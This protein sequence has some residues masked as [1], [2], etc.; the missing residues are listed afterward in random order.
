MS[1]IKEKSDS[2]SFKDNDNF[3]EFLE[4]K[5]QIINLLQVNCEETNVKSNKNEKISTRLKNEILN[6]IPEK[7]FY[8]DFVARNNLSSSKVE[9]NKTQKIKKEFSSSSISRIIFTENKD[10]L[11]ISNE[12]NERISSLSKNVVNKNIVDNIINIDLRKSRYTY[13]SNEIIKFIVFCIVIHM[14]LKNPLFYFNG[15]KR[16]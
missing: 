9:Y 11:K 8:S 10:F 5:K 3:Q 4:G 6:I 2:L 1:E 12:F 16:R 14:N 13:M 15:I 7:N